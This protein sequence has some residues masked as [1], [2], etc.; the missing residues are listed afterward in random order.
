MRSNLALAYQAAGRTAATITVHEQN[1]A[2]VC[3]SWSLTTPAPCYRATTSLQ[4]TRWLPAPGRP[5]LASLVVMP[6]IIARGCLL[7]P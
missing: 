3:G 6:R 7:P 4:P 2:A 1:L 5:R